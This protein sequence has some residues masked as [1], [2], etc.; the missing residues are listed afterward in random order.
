LLLTIL[1]SLIGAGLVVAVYAVFVERNWFA[2]RTHRVP[3]LPPG[4]APMRVLHVS[5]LHLRSVQR[6]KQ[7]FLRGLA[8][9]QPDVIVGTGDFLGDHLSVDA[10]LSALEPIPKRAA[11]FVLG[12]N[13][14]YGPRFKNPIRYFIPAKKRG[15]S[16]GTQN[17]WPELVHGLEARGWTFADNETLTIDGIDVLGLGDAHIGRADMR[18]ATPRAR[19]GFRLA[20]A[21]SPDVAREL[22]G[23]GYDLIVCGHTH[24]GQ[25]CV[26]G[27]GA[28]VTNCALPRDMA[29]G[30]HRIGDAWLHVSGG[31]GTSMF[32]PYRLACR[33]EVCVLELVPR[34][35]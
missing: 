18:L 31:L 29:K 14:Y 6:R 2:V 23:K 5:D 19:D 21:H 20:V 9:V 30:L 8:R 33:P 32:A 17:P 12:S 22:A 24:G 13:D 35:T 27:V 4:A 25:V 34:A 10:T 28:L 7:R 15:R 26:P 3:C 16:H 1:L 11:L